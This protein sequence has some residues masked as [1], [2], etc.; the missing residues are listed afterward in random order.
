MP[1]YY[2]PPYWR[3]QSNRRR[4]HQVHKLTVFIQYYVAAWCPCQLFKW[5][6]QQSHVITI[7]R[8]PR[9]DLLLQTGCADGDGGD[10]HM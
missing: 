2:I 6:I 10:L 9:A 5:P 1:R 4:K 3:K 7:G 8:L